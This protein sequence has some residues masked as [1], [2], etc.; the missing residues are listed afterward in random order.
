M[1]LIEFKNVFKNFSELEILQ[2]IDFSIEEETSVSITGKSGS[3]KSTFLHLAGGLDSASE[4]EVLCNGKNWRKL[5]DKEASKLRNEEI[6]FI[7][8]SNLLLEDFNVLENVMMPALI[9]GKKESQCK[10]RAQMLLERLGLAERLSQKASKLSGGEKQRVSI[11][12]ALINNPKTILAD[13]PTG[14]LDEKNATE[15]ENLLLE[16]VKEQGCSLLLVTHNPD[17]ASRCDVLYQ[18]SMGKLERKSAK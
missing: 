3:G 14:S 15:V 5:N 13:E 9:A 6:G 16:L 8:Q 17:F 12:R 11:C 4:G 1:K 2:G 7:F 10:D 18:L